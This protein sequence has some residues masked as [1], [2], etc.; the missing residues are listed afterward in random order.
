MKL[1]KS[2]LWI[3]LFLILCSSAFAVSPVL[4]TIQQ[5]QL[6]IVPKIIDSYQVNTFAQL[7]FHVFNMTGHQLTNESILKYADPRCYIHIYQ[8]DGQHKLE[9]ELL[10]SRED[11]DFYLDLNATNTSRIGIYPYIVWCNGTYAGWIESQFYVTEHAINVPVDKYPNFDTNLIFGLMVIAFFL[12]YFSDKFKVEGTNA[13]K[14]ISGLLIGQLFKLS[15]FGIIILD[16]FLIR[17]L[18]PSF[19]TIMPIYDVFLTVFTYGVA[20]IFFIL[21][22]VNSF[23]TL[24]ENFKIWKQNKRGKDYD[25]DEDDY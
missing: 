9:T 24:V 18:I 17:N 1:H 20:F 21:F 2:F 5:G 11:G 15:A 8:Q 10:Y 14:S 6:D 25:E 4:Q 13:S 23:V 16:V 7:N 3:G 22:F 19:V 12:V